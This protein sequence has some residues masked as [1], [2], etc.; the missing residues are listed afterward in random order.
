MKSPVEPR[1]LHG[2]R[3]LILESFVRHVAERGYDGTN[4]SDIA[5]ELGISKG[6]I[7][8]H[9][10]SK[11]RMLAEAHERYMHRRIAEATVIVTALRTPSERLAGLVLAGLL[12]Q[13]EDRSAT[14]A[15]QREVNRFRDNGVMHESQ[16]LRAEYLAILVSVLDEGIADGSFRLVDTRLVAT[17]IMSVNQWAWT[18]Y[19]PDDARPPEAVAAQFNDL[20]QGGLVNDRAKLPQPAAL[21][22]HIA[23]VVRSVIAAQRLEWGTGPTGTPRRPA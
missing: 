6:T 20:F 23:P 21:S 16:K 11:D 17:A 15:F 5:T 4:L 12:Y 9:F 19:E 7:V 3:D 2:R 22:K 8:H 18:W 14:I 1:R 10:T 13:H